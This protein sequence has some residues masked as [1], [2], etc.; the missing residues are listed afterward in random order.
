M[1][2]LIHKIVTMNHWATMYIGSAY[3]LIPR[4]PIEGLGY[5]QPDII[6]FKMVAAFG[7]E[8]MLK[9]YYLTLLN[10]PDKD[11][12]SNEE[13]IRFLKKEQLYTHKLKF[14]LSKIKNKDNTLKN[15]SKA[16]TIQDTINIFD[17]FEQ[18]RYPTSIKSPTHL[19]EYDSNIFE[20]F[21]QT[22]MY[23]RGKI[24]KYIR[25]L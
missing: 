7:L 19:F 25:D 23:F 8:L 16:K 22:R 14:L 11:F 18:A 9:T 4:E 10:T 5:N 12:S 3:S 6:S 2:Y 24:N 15:T 20:S 1:V 13:Y 17:C 21:G